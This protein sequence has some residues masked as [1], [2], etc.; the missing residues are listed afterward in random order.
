MI[1]LWPD[2]FKHT[3]YTYSHDVVSSTMS[4]S[5]LKSFKVPKERLLPFAHYNLSIAR[6]KFPRSAYKCDYLSNKLRDSEIA[7]HG[8]EGDENMNGRQTNYGKKA[9]NIT[10]FNVQ[11]KSKKKTSQQR[12][13]AFIAR[14]F[15]IEYF[16]DGSPNGN[17]RKKQHFEL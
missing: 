4:L 2:F 8:D 9:V 15:H 5:H 6:D 1:Q 14:F 7:M 13:E 16:I 17:H 12:V 11:W 3:N 10:W